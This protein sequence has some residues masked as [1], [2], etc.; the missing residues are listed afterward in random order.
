[1]PTFDLKSAFKTGTRI[2]VEPRQYFID[3]HLKHVI[4]A[5]SDGEINVKQARTALAAFN[6]HLDDVRIAHVRFKELVNMRDDV[7]KSRRKVGN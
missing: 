2:P 1:M 4:W 7:A 6:K 3:V 5:W